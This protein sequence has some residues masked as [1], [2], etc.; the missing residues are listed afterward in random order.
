MV[1][2]KKWK[3]VIPEKI[4]RKMEKLPEKDQKELMKGIKKL[5]ENPYAGKPFNGIEIRAWEN[6]KCECEEPFRMV[7]ELDD[8]EVHFSCRKGACD[9]SFWCTKNELIKGRKKYVK[10][11]QN[12]GESLKYRDIEFVE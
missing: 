4:V 10:D 6:E 8:K 2:E 9:E 7:L 5:S 11:A 3:V 12:V 1:N